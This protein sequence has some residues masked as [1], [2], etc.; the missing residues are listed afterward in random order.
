MNHPKSYDIVV[1]GAGHAGCEASLSTARMGC[2]TLLLTMNIENVAQMSCNP[3]IGGL[4]KSHLVKE[5]DALGGEMGRIADKTALQ[6]RMLN[7]SRGP[8]VWALRSQNDRQMYNLCMR[9]VVENQRGLDLR[10]ARV[11]RL[12]VEDGRVV[13]VA[14]DTG[15]SVRAE[16]V[17]IATGTFLGGTIH[18]GLTSYA[19][20][21]NGECSSQ[22]LSDDLRSHGFEIGRL[23]TGTSPR[24]DGKTIEFDGLQAEVGDKGIE[25]FSH[26]T[27]GSI[28]SRMSCYLTR[29]NEET[30]RII[31][32]SL[33]RS[34]LY[35]GKIDG[36]GPR[37][38]P[39]IEDKVMRFPDRPTHQVFLE[40]EGEHTTEYYLSGLAT[41][42]PEDVQIQM[43]R[44]IP[45]LKRARISRPGYAV[46]YDF[47]QPTE[48]HPT[49][50]TKR[51]GGLYLAG[52]I[53]GTSGYE[54][55][56]AQGLMAGVNA[57]LG[58]SGREQ[59]ILGRDE[60]YI[61][62]LID[63]LVTRGTREP[64]RMFTSRAEY[65]LILR[66]DNAD[67]RLM[68][69]GHR[70]GLI[71]DKA[72]AGV[73]DRKRGLEALRER[74]RGSRIKEGAGSVTLEQALRRPGTGWNDL[75]GAA[76]WLD[77]YDSRLLIRAETEIKYEGYIQREAGK[78]RD[79][80]RKGRKVIPPQLDYAAVAG[81]SLE[82]TEKLSRVRPGSIGQASRI[83]GITP[84]DL[85]SVL[86][87]LAKQARL[88]AEG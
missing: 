17:I 54:E 20:G 34:P 61:G 66:Q 46:E 55:A 68:Q 9:E 70:L 60:A 48:L 12:L 65:R 88:G 25:P 30:H 75:A 44:T 7:R 58:V 3:A 43:V 72:L 27:R 73:E 71:T 16:A 63:D 57:A 22:G 5:I 21:R 1:I 14:T 64:Y 37:Y 18:V 80:R 35:T 42:L 53:N 50:Q 36:V 78:A 49:L 83:P 69:Y 26:K 33:D 84:A 79:L 41:S 59:L 40:P 87:H 39:S 24:I 45:G 51:L 85:S 10:Q 23:K 8:A 86:I 67:E 56:A 28:E 6:V 29:T 38:C 11:E 76:P 4:A 82:A 13:G 31:R 47:V 32:S 77:E 81:L 19:G 62:V 2:C 52:Q 15:Y 74:L